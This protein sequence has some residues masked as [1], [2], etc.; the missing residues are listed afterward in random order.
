MNNLEEKNKFCSKTGNILWYILNVAMVFTWTNNLLNLLME[1]FI[2]DNFPSK[3]FSFK[4]KFNQPTRRWLSKMPATFHFKHISTHLYAFWCVLAT[5]KALKTTFHNADTDSFD[6]ASAHASKT[7]AWKH[8]LYHKSGSVLLSC[9]EVIDEFGGVERDLSLKRKFWFSFETSS[10]FKSLTCWI[11][12]A[13]LGTDVI[14]DRWIVKF[15]VATFARISKLSQTIFN[16]PFVICI[17]ITFDHSFIWTAIIT[18]CIFDCVIAST[19]LELK[20]VLAFRWWLLE[21]SL[22]LSIKH[23]MRVTQKA[24]SW[25]IVG[26]NRR[27]G[28]RKKCVRF[29]WRRIFVNL[30]EVRLLV[31]EIS[32]PVVLPFL[33][34]WLIAVLSIVI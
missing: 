27:A 4:T 12:F 6:C 10:L 18:R 2:P 1:W 8:K 31:F 33:L 19:V 34:C 22:L 17:F 11:F 13:T 3:L 30:L 5:T 20:L 16:L 9:L 15:T 14:G 28:R 25:V 7:P 24:F 29:W 32:L 26:W 21:W 23:F